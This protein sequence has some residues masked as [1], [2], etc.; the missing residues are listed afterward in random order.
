MLN[1]I[2]RRFL[3][4]F[5]YF[6]SFST[7]IFS[8]ES[9]YIPYSRNMNEYHGFS[10]AI[11][12][13]TARC[14]QP[15][16]YNNISVPF[17]DCNGDA[18]NKDQEG[19]VID[20]WTNSSQLNFSLTIDARYSTMRHYL[21]IFVADD[22]NSL[23]DDVRHQK[24]KRFGRVNTPHG[25]LKT[26]DTIPAI[27]LVGKSE[28][29]IGLRSRCAADIGGNKTIQDSY[30]LRIFRIHKASIPSMV[31]NLS[32]DDNPSTIFK[33]QQISNKYYFQPPSN[34]SFTVP[35]FSTSTLE[36]KRLKYNYN[37]NWHSDNNTTFENL[38][39]TIDA[40]YS[41]KSIFFDEQ[42][43]NTLNVVKDSTPPTIT[44]FNDH[45]SETSNELSKFNLSSQYDIIDSQSGVR[46]VWYAL[47]DVTLGVPMN[48][49][50]TGSADEGENTDQTG[51]PDDE[52]D[53][54]MLPDVG[55]PSKYSFPFEGFFRDNLYQ[56]RVIAKDNVTNE[57]PG[58]E[59]IFGLTRGPAFDTSPIL[60]QK[61]GAQ[62]LSLDI[63]LGAYFAHDEIGYSS[64]TV[65][66]NGQPVIELSKNDIDQMY[67]D[68]GE[69]ISSIFDVSTDEDK[70]KIKKA[71]LSYPLSTIIDIDP[72]NAHKTYEVTLEATYPSGHSEVSAKTKYLDF[73]NTGF[74]GDNNFTFSFYR[75]GKLIEDL[76][77]EDFS[78]NMYLFY[79]ENFQ[80]KLDGVGGNGKDLEGD[81]L[82]LQITDSTGTSID[83]PAFE[84]LISFTAENSVLTVRTEAGLEFFMNSKE[85]DTVSIIEK[86]DREKYNNEEGVIE[87]VP[88]SNEF[89]L[90][91]AIHSDQDFN[92]ELI[93]T[94]FDISDTQYHQWEQTLA[95]NDGSFKW[96]ISYGTDTEDFY[97]T[98]GIQEVT[99]FEYD[100][101]IEEFTLYDFKSLP[102][103]QKVTKEFQ[104]GE[105]YQL[106]LEESLFQ[107]STETEGTAS[108]RKIGVY[109]QD[110]AGHNKIVTQ[111]VYYDRQAPLPLNPD[112][113]VVRWFASEEESENLWYN[114]FNRTDNTITLKFDLED[115]LYGGLESCYSFA[116]LSSTIDAVLI[117]PPSQTI[118]E[119]QILNDFLQIQIPE[120]FPSDTP[121]NLTLTFTD[122]AG[123]TTVSNMVLY[124]PLYFAQS[125][126]SV[127]IRETEE[128]WDDQM[129]EPL[130]HFLAWNQIQLPENQLVLYDQVSGIACSSVATFGDFVHSGL[131]A[132]DK[133][134]YLLHGKNRSGYESEFI[135]SEGE[136]KWT[137]LSLTR[138]L[139]NN[140]PFVTAYEE[141]GTYENPGDGKYLGPLNTL[142]VHFEDYD[143]TDDFLIRYFVND[144][145]HKEFKVSGTLGEAG[146]KHEIAVEDFFP[147]FEDSET[148]EIR[149]EILDY[150]KNEE[151]Q[152]E[153]TIVL[154]PSEVYT[155]DSVNPDLTNFSYD[156]R[157]GFAYING[158]I[159][160]N[161]T[162][163]GSGLKSRVL[164]EQA[165]GEFQDLSYPIDLS[166]GDDLEGFTHLISQIPDLRDYT[167]YL[168]MEDEV[169]NFQIESIGPFSKDSVD[170]VLIEVAIDKEK[171]LFSRPSIP[172]S[173]SWTDNLSGASKLLY[174]FYQ[175]EEVIKSG[176]AAQSGDLLGLLSADWSIY[177]S[178]SESLLNNDE[179]ALRVKILDNAGNGEDADWTTI[180]EDIQID[181]SSPVITISSLEG[182][183]YNA[184]QYYLSNQTSP[185]IDYQINDENPTGDVWY[186]LESETET[187]ENSSLSFLL[188]NLS[189]GREYSLRV[190]SVD[191]A[192][193]I[194]RSS[195]LT[196][197]ADSQSPDTSSYSM[198]LINPADF[199][200]GQQV[201]FKFSAEDEHSGIETIHL[202]IGHE[203]DGE[204]LPV[205]SSILPGHRDDGSVDLTYGQ[206]RTFSLNLP[207]VPEGYYFFRISTTDYAGNTSGYKIPSGETIHIVDSDESLVVQ[208]FSIYH[209]D[210]YALSGWWNYEGDK[211]FNHYAYRVRN[212]ETGSPV[213]DWQY[214]FDNYGSVSFPDGMTSGGIYY[215]EVY[216]GF[217]DGSITASRFSPGTLIDTDE[218]EISEIRIPAYGTLAGLNVG[219]DANDDLTAIDQVLV[220][221]DTYRYD[222][223]GTL[224]TETY[225]Q[226][227]TAVT[228]PVREEIGLYPVGT[229]STGENVHILKAEDFSG[230]NIADGQKIFVTL[231][232]SD[233]AGNVSE[234]S[235]GIFIKDSSAP[236]VP[237]VLDEGDFINPE[238]DTVAF[239]WQWSPQDKHSG[240]ARYFYQIL[241]D[242]EELSDL[243][244][245][246]DGTELELGNAAETYENG[247][248]LTLAVQV[249]N[250]AGL[251]TVGYS[252]GIVLD[253]TKPARATTTLLDDEGNEADYLLGRN[254][255][256]SIA[257][258]DDESGI[259]QYLYQPGTFSGTEWIPLSEDY[260]ELPSSDQTSPVTVPEELE[261]LEIIY[262]KAMAVNTAGD[263]SLP[264]Y[265]S[266][267]KIFD[268]TPLIHNLI[269]ESVGGTLQYT[270]DTEDLVPLDT[271]TLKLRRSGTLFST[272]V[273]EGN[274]RNFTYEDLEDGIYTLQ[275]DYTAVNAGTSGK[276]SLSPA[277]CLDTTSPT[278]SS[279]EYTKFVNDIFNYN[280]IIQ[281]NLTGG[282]GYRFRMG[283][284]G[285]P[286]VLT[287]GWRWLDS[288][289]SYQAKTVS[290]MDEFAG[291]YDSL[292]DGGTILFS[293]QVQ[294]LAG[295]WSDIYYSTPI[296]VDRT[297]P[298]I[299]VI[300][301]NRDIQVGDTVYSQEGYYIIRYDRVENITIQGLDEESGITG[302]RWAVQKEDSS[303][304]P[305]WK[306]FTGYTAEDSDLTISL[307]DVVLPDLIL[308]DKTHYKLLIQTRNGSGII[309]EPGELSSL[310]SDFSAPAFEVDT[311][312]SG[313]AW[314]ESENG[315]GVIYNTG[316]DLLVNVLGEDGEVIEVN[317]SLIDP[318]SLEG[319][320]I[321]QY[322]LGSNITDITI[323]FSP[324]D[325]SRYGDYKLRIALS[326]SGGYES[327][328]YQDI[329]LNAPPSF[330]LKD[331]V[332]NPMKPFDLDLT[333]W[334]SDQDEVRNVAIEIEHHGETESWHQPLLQNLTSLAF[335]HEI[336]FAGETEYSYTVSAEDK[337]GQR[338]SSEGFIKIVN[339]SEGTLYTDEYWTGPHQILG[340][341]TVPDGLS[342]SLADST[343]VDIVTGEDRR[344]ISLII[345]PDAEL[346]HLGTSTY[347]LFD[348]DLGILW[349]GLYVKGTADLSD[350]TVSGAERG[351]TLANGQDV[352]IS[353][354]SFV[355]NTI[356]LHLIGS[357]PE[358]TGCEFSGNRFYGLKEDQGS[359][360][361]MTDNLFLNNG[362]DYYDLEQT[363]ISADELNYLDGNAGNRGEN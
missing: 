302:Y 74:D 29:Y 330:S 71:I 152:E 276:T 289:G 31:G 174:E 277:V 203:V 262:Y 315:T 300:D 5:I 91:L 172:V 170:P 243:W 244:I 332:S 327:V 150:W 303:D 324:L 307:T 297:A 246:A 32:I 17:P 168:R 131:G 154:N 2:I 141:I 132:H 339:T 42:K 217:D 22:I 337:F 287:Q 348:P 135:T 163:D 98:S 185:S 312:N 209:N 308:E 295:N 4:I 293:C 18:T 296:L 198:T 119:I 79:D 343:T 81:N 257:S 128:E 66:F 292:V 103:E 7:A 48:D 202:L 234:K 240:N 359:Q 305:E 360:P 108:L 280:F 134:T 127:Y 38:D 181:A 41:G 247:S 9:T 176:E 326:D 100:N 28:I 179:I 61:D 73:P 64:Y 350:I 39:R 110:F 189:D 259:S 333:D 164:Y 21:T 34:I 232:V 99:F 196:F 149:Y 122:Y 37:G 112:S 195:P 281:D 212:A 86:F 16:Y 130:G 309:S 70:G 15:L 36:Y 120:D 199:V 254:A 51:N 180:S 274:L 40:V 55:D 197:I 252:N 56:V 111:D 201:R 30:R 25:E 248:Q 249:E 325:A 230:L 12:N 173:L 94:S 255:V 20:L 261:S 256:L 229:G 3:P 341:V 97:D 285:A 35:T 361:V 6:F 46:S 191:Q 186:A 118:P 242:S 260:L 358:I 54:P 161:I 211:E 187:I 223:E 314:E 215:F 184:G 269:G 83:I 298:E 144:A 193:N 347:Q 253:N 47:D 139:Q 194:G 206:D 362:Y 284:A 346:D 310:V 75:G 328:L 80:L 162:E 106:D 313:L 218:P 273:V 89:P 355:N 251:T 109:I 188:S 142:I 304:E 250:R 76:H 353:G 216:A 63:A 331:V 321:T 264:G 45:Y 335:D 183:K 219:W 60:T 171:H 169:G 344:D 221:L 238:K 68:L 82:F 104:Y 225:F 23:L 85:I 65:N 279:L 208:D 214:T 239:H 27:S 275:L 192:G 148:Y 92:S 351:V 13:Y 294:D 237:V 123:N 62:E 352:R 157:K 236:P 57:H 231:Q 235:G 44:P 165:D 69:E 204:F 182:W 306:D 96:D 267:A 58:L 53:E 155:Y 116:E 101:A 233:L 43:S 286:D 220:K 107:L 258:A 33:D 93:N 14:A 151:V 143:D 95:T 133:R 146:L 175:D 322:Y 282:R 224:I 125:D 336:Q 105:D 124:T 272:D 19:V 115:E 265:S 205:V 291:G 88:T 190:Y 102:D 213:S 178:L 345:E 26:N 270:W 126:P 50:V 340:T 334:I 77:F 160:L 349:N 210:P 228:V 113:G 283:P 166:T 317:Y 147:D 52:E 59:T 84:G 290:F 136:Q 10:R 301:M 8:F 129:E 319:E 177:C 318:D 288:T 271:I 137:E 245:A 357:S 338:S 311:L 117:D 90:N 138:K 158:D 329:R 354:T 49:E 1:N 227:G 316:G 320:S 278:V 145:F 222:S 207:D 363:V 153:G 241:R 24:K 226:D 121:I 140:S 268:E 342:L 11:A 167:L 299:P 67:S 159:H 156:Q 78:E 72:T 323:P 356:G 263:S 266:G 87:I 114:S 200:Q